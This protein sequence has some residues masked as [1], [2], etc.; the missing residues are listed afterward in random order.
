MNGEEINIKELKTFLNDLT[1][2]IF[3]MLYG[4]VGNPD[5]TFRDLIE[6]LEKAFPKADRVIKEKED[7]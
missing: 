4:H 1:V 5:N 6:Q 2:E 3:P 7:D